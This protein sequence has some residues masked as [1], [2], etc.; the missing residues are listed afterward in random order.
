MILVFPYAFVDVRCDTNVQ[1]SVATTRKD[2]HAGL[3]RHALI[4]AEVLRWRTRLD[5]GFHRYDGPLRH[6]G[7]HSVRHPGESRDPDAKLM[8]EARSLDTGFHRYDG[9]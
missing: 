4:T 6:P 5:T 8:D 2:I 9:T 7:R 1:R 3:L